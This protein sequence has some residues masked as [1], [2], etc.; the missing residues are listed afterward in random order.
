MFHQIHW[1]VV[2]PWMAISGS[3]PPHRTASCGSYGCAYENIFI[4]H[5]R[6]VPGKN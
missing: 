5:L 3:C 6:S 2:G 1:R 4:M